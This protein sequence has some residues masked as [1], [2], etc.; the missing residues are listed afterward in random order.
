MENLFRSNTFRYKIKFQ[1]IVGHRR[2]SNVYRS[3]SEVSGFKNFGL[4]R[5]YL[6]KANGSQIN[7][8][9]KFESGMYKVNIQKQVPICV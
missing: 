9:D 8:T 1:G 4:F 6:K 5:F 7:N 3:I 2:L